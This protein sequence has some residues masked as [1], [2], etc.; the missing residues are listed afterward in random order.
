MVLILVKTVVCTTRGQRITYKYMS[1]Y[2]SWE[3][4]TSLS[5]LYT[6]VIGFVT[7]LDF[8]FW[9]TLWVSVSGLSLPH[10]ALISRFINRL[11]QYHSQ[12]GQTSCHAM[13]EVQVEVPGDWMQTLFELVCPLAPVL[14]HWQ[15]DFLGPRLLPGLNSD[16]SPVTQCLHGWL[17]L[18]NTCESAQNASWPSDFLFYCVYCV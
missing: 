18:T 11:Q 7:C 17:Y 13:L 10:K 6:T 16:G 12:W 8:L 5:E 15:G 4:Q 1:M 3:R 14:R 2:N 9:L